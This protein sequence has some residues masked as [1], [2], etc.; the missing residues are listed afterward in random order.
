MMNV[1]MDGKIE[2]QVDRKMDGWMDRLV[3]GWMVNF[4]FMNGRQTNV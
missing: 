3:N 2:R 1:V 4:V